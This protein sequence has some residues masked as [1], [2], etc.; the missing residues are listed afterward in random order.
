MIKEI[1]DHLITLLPPSLITKFI[2]IGWQML[3][4]YAYYYGIGIDLNKV[5]LHVV[6]YCQ[7]NNVNILLKGMDS[8]QLSFNITSLLILAS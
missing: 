2:D 6:D 3:L 5:S 8:V 1:N 7:I 4:G